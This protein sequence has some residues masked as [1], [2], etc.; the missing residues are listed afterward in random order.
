MTSPRT[1]CSTT[2][3]KSFHEEVRE[4]GHRVDAK[5]GNGVGLRARV[6][7]RDGDDLRVRGRQ[8]VSLT[9]VSAAD[10]DLWMPTSLVAFD[11]D[12]VARGHPGKHFVQGGLGPSS[13]LMH[14]RPPLGRSDR[15]L[16]GTGF[17]VPVAVAPRVVDVERDVGM[18]YRGDAKPSGYQLGD[19]ASCER[20]LSRVLP[21]H[22]SDDG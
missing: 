15:D 5:D 3:L 21:A 17:S 11:N 12:H 14:H 1:S 8:V 4:Q 19:E 16:M 18:L 6:V 22:H 20:G 13:K 10:L 9:G 2:Q 7:G